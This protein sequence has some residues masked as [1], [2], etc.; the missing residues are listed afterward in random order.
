[1]HFL[2]FVYYHSEFVTDV[3]TEPEAGRGTK[4]FW[5]AH[6]CPLIYH[7]MDEPPALP[8]GGGWRPP[9]QP[10]FLTIGF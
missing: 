7:M 5:V 10:S 3:W 6:W 9:L 8:S 4:G 2:P 1:M